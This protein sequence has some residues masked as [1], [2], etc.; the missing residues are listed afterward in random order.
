MQN[1]DDRPTLDRH[2][3]SPSGSLSRR[4]FL[5]VAGAAGVVLGAGSGLGGVLSACGGGSSSSGGGSSTEPIKFGILGAMGDPSGLNV[6]RAAELSFGAI[7]ASGG[8]LGRQCEIVGPIDD[9]METAQAIQGFETLLAKKVDV[10]LGASID[11][12]EAALLSRISRAQDVLYLSMFASTQA[13]MVNV[14]TDYDKF[15]NYFMYTP[16]DEGLYFC[17][18]DPAVQLMNDYGYKKVHMLR[19]DMVWTEGIEVFFKEEA[20]KAGLVPAG[21]SVVPV[22]VEDLTPYFRAA[23]QAGAQQIMTFISV[24]GERLANQAWENKVPMAIAGHNGILN[25]YGYWERSKGAWG[26]MATTSTWGS[27]QKH[28][29]EWRDYVSKWFST[30]P[31][32]PR[33]PMWLGECTWRG[34]KSY[35]E[36]AE[37]ANSVA[38]EALIPELEKTYYAD[39][40]TRGGFYGPGQGDWPHAWCSP[41]DETAAASPDPERGAGLWESSPW[42]PMTQWQPPDIAPADSFMLPGEPADYGRLVTVYPKYLAGG[43]YQPPPFFPG[44]PNA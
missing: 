44:S 13:F 21:V 1:E 37:R 4:D 40:P 42:S 12:V 11:D 9:H 17:V 43:N 5:K 15:K 7:N 35:K 30:Y 23:E 29:V 19:E 10:I 33:T 22:D 31:D 41:I 28:T 6:L 20:P 39:A 25:D 8:I 27:L 14:N 2:D 38:T 18:Q 36:A 3:A 24:F 34:I 26:T 32:D 16:T